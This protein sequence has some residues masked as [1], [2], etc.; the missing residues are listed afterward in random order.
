MPKKIEMVA[1]RPVYVRGDRKEYKAGQK[2]TVSS[3]DEANRLER[4]S[5]ATRAL[6]HKNPTDLP[7]AI[8]AA[9]NDL[10]GLRAEYREVAG[11][12]PFMGW[13]AAILR[14]KIAEYRTTNMGDSGLTTHLTAQ[15]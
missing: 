3:E 10:P 5:R 6:G 2:F 9:S 14:Q 15:E 12:G 13:D 11:K 7:A 8:S 4:R 1:S